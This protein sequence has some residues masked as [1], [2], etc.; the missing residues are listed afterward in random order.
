VRDLDP[1]IPV[2]QVSTLHEVLR[3]SMARLTLMLSVLSAAAAVSVLLGMIGLYGVMGYLVA[4][5]RRE[6]GLRMALGAEP[7]RIARSVLGRGLML[8]AIGAALGLILF[9]LAA[10]L[11][12]ASVFGVA[13]WDPVSL[14]GATALVLCMALLA[15]WIP[16]RRAAALDPAQALRAE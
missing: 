7:G 2:F 5:R 13:A 3:S 9:A 11:M 16:A 8:S 14:A 1:S 6:F 10:S 4:L 15:C 12:H